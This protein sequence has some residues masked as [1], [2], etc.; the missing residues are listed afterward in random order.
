MLDAMGGSHEAAFLP[1]EIGPAPR[2]NANA[3]RNQQL[4]QAGNGLRAHRACWPPPQ[5]LPQVITIDTQRQAGPTHNGTDGHDRP[6][7]PPDQTHQYSAAQIRIWTPR[8]VMELI[9][10]LQA[11]QGFAMRPFPRGHKGLTLDANGK[12]E[13]A[14][15]DYLNM[16]ISQ[17]D[18][19]PSP[20]TAWS[21]P[22]SKLTTRRSSS[23]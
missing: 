2:T 20:A 14:G 22:T 3:S 11:E 16:V 6:A 8:R 10:V 17:R 9:R 18:S 15:E 12:L 23:S 7:L 13:P 19:P 21:S 5:P 1:S 4:R